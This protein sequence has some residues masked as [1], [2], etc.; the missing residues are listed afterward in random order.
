MSPISNIMQGPV[1]HC[2]LMIH[3]ACRIHLF[4]PVF[5]TVTSCD[6]GCR[7]TGPSSV[8]CAPANLQLS[9]FEL[10]LDVGAHAAHKPGSLKI[11][12]NECLL[13]ADPNSKLM[14]S[15]STYSPVSF[16]AGRI[17][18]RLAFYIGLQHSSGELSSTDAQR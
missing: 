14:Q 2:Q 4:L 15:V 6:G 5:L 11:S 3:L 10:V 1:L 13:G 12:K 17:T 18:L 9:A 16:L 8:H 7:L